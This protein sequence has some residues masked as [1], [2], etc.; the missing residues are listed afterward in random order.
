[1]L[2]IYSV[3]QIE[4]LRKISRKRSSQIHPNLVQGLLVIRIIPVSVISC[5]HKEI[6]CFDSVSIPVALDIS[7]S[8]EY[9]FH[10]E[11]PVEVLLELCRTLVVIVRVRHRLPRSNDIKTVMAYLFMP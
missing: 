10:N 5:K 2:D 8:F 1:M 11:K 4:S 3:G 6:P 9:V 7:L